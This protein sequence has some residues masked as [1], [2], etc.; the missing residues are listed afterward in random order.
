V[1]LE[2]VKLVVVVAL[3]GASA[4]TIPMT[5]GVSIGRAAGTSPKR[6]M[7]ATVHQHDAPICD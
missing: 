2:P 1:L 5:G 6:V 7:L 3:I 4:I